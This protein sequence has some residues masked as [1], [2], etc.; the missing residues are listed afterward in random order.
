MIV[1][2]STHKYLSSTIWCGG[3]V[4]DTEDTMVKKQSSSCPHKAYILGRQTINNTV[5]AVLTRAMGK[6]IYK[7]M[8]GDGEGLL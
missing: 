3:A 6:K 1:I 5:M 7:R 2:Y 4:L 8:E